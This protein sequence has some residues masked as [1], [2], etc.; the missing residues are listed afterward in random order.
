MAKRRAERAGM[1][2][3]CTLQPKS[4]DRYVCRKCLAY[5]R[6]WGRRLR[7]KRISASRCPS[8]GKQVAHAD[9]KTCA[10]C[11]ER[12]AVSQMLR[13]AMGHG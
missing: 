13:R 6:E 3:Q 10:R 8:C 11:A 5:N 9:I 4:A 12:A 1:C 2:T 7:V